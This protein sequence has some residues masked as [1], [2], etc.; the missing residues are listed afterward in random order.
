MDFQDTIKARVFAKSVTFIPQYIKEFDRNLTKREQEIAK[1]STF[2]I[3]KSG[4][5]VYIY[6]RSHIPESNPVERI[7]L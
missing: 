1:A 5:K 7:C 2:K 4:Q 3:C 6:E